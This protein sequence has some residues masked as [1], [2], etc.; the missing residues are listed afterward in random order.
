MF[1]KY[2]LLIRMEHLTWKSSLRICSAHFTE[3]DFIV[4]GGKKCL[5]P[6]ALP[7]LNIPE[8]DQT[9]EDSTLPEMSSS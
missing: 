8:S 4:K 2:L 9:M 7:F 5:G 1:K 6:N 3:E